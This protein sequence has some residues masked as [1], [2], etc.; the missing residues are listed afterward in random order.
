V[1]LCLFFGNGHV[2][3]NLFDSAL[4]WA[5][6]A[7]KLMNNRVFSLSLPREHRRKEPLSQT[8]SNVAPTKTTSD[9]ER[10]VYNWLLYCSKKSNSL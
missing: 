8:N 9:S 10:L 5:D 4:R 2:I 7:D 3:T 1:A 6:A